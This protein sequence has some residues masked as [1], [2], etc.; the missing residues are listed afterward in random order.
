MESI[1]TQTVYAVIDVKERLPTKHEDTVF[2]DDSDT[3]MIDVIDSK[4]NA[5][6]DIENYTHWLEKKEDMVCMSRKDFKEAISNAIFHGLN[7]ESYQHN[8]ESFEKPPV[9]GST[10]INNLFK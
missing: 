6:G 3:V 10:Y 4:G 9:G 1:N 8:P 7:L 2:L 5:F